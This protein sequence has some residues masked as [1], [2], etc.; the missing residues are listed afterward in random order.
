MTQSYDGTSKKLTLTFEQ[1][2]PDTAGQTNKKPMHIPIS[3]GLIGK[4]GNDIHTQLLELKETKQEFV[5]NNLKERPV[6]SSLRGFSA[7]VKL[8]TDLS[9]DELRFLMVHDSDG[10]NRWDAGQTLALK[11]L[12]GMIAGDENTDTAYINA[13]SGAIDA[14]KDKRPAL[15]ARVLALPDYSILSQNM[16]PIYPQAMKAAKDK[17][18]K[19][20]GTALIDKLEIIYQSAL[21]NN[22]SK[23]S[24]ADHMGW[25]SLMNIALEYITAAD[26]QKGLTLAKAQYNNAYC[27]TERMGALTVMAD[28]KGADYQTALA[29]F[30]ER[31][32]DYELVVNKW[33]G[34]QA[35]CEHN[36]VIDD[37]KKL[38]QHSDFTLKNPNRV[39][40]LIAAFAMR[41]MTMFHD[42]SGEGYKLLR[43]VVQELN[44]INPQIASRMLTPLRQWTAFKPELKE[45]MYKELLI[46]RDMP[47]LSPDVFEVITKTLAAGEQ[48]QAA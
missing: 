23:S 16:S 6:V 38:M 35:S 33:F 21:D 30:Y 22:D 47:N 36:E 3:I 29:D 43:E 2:I 27:M 42:E 26:N 31:F 5:F 15:L 10:F 13:L 8:K 17:A 37:V 48:T 28:H 39:R 44:T 14:L 24:H 32:K 20:I 41:N 46:L 12:L 19:D 4:N 25:R 34:L 1:Y 7:P 40:S 11:M 45:L 9:D 18:M